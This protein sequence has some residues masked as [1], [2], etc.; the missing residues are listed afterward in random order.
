MPPAG[1]VRRSDRQS[2]TTR[3]EIGSS[4]LCV[5]SVSRYNTRPR[6]ARID[7][8]RPGRER[9]TSRSAL[10]GGDQHGHVLPEPRT[11]RLSNVSTERRGPRSRSRSSGVTQPRRV[12][13]TG[14]ASESPLT[15]W[16][17][18]GDAQSR[19]CATS[20]TRRGYGRV[21]TVSVASASTPAAAR[22]PRSATRAFAAS[23]SV[24]K[25]PYTRDAHPGVSS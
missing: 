21:W 18:R 3:R 16:A 23:T 4:V 20:K 25:V 15:G 2:R 22:S 6:K 10:V 24:S 5:A 8:R 9:G 19:R 11:R 1:G 13:M 7:E 12:E 17:L 14:S